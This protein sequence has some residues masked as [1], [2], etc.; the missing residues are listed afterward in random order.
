VLVGL[1]VLLLVAAGAG[2]GAWYLGAGRYTTTPSVLKLTAN[3]AHAKLATSGLKMT[4]SKPQYSE[5][6][7]AG[8]VIS[9]D[10]APGQRVAK[11]GTV[12]VVLSLGKL[13]YKVPPVIGLTLSGATAALTAQ[14]L[15][16]GTTTQSYSPSVVVGRVISASP[17]AGAS[18]KTGTPVNLVV[19]KGLPPVAVP[20]L[21]GSSLANANQLAAAANL[22]LN[23][24]GQ[25]ASMTVPKGDVISQNPAPGTQVAQNSSVAIVVSTGP[26][27]VA[28]PD[29]VGMSTNDA[30]KAL[31]NAGFKVHTYNELPTVLLDTVYTQ[32]PG[33]GSKAPKGSTVNLGIV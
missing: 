13:R 25:Q 1:L 11:N 30:R 32:N 24:T 6:V 18:L 12:A 21:V 26:P 20:K 7:T 29:V 8:Y 15:A 16:V 9:S 31:K 22:Q 28:V 33:G 17:A 19:S 3:Q 23:Q 5:I 2:V 10:P 27:L 14:H 4:E